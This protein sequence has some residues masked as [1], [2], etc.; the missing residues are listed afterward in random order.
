M[1][2]ILTIITFFHLFSSVGWA[3]ARV[4]EIE[5]FEIRSYDPQKGGLTDLVFEARIGNLTEI[6]NKVQ[7]FG[8]LV[9]VYF[10]IYWI[11]PAQYKVEVL[12]LPKGFA[13][14]RSDLGDLIKGK[15]EFIIPERFSEKFKGYTFKVEPLSSGKLIKA[16]D[17]SY[18]MAVP[19][20]D[21]IFDSAGRLKTLETKRTYTAMKSDF[22]HSPKSWSNG[23][24]VLDKIITT[25]TSGLT[26]KETSSIVDYTSIAGIGLPSKV[27]IKNIET[28]TIPA[29]GKEK[30]KIIKNESGTVVK[31]SNYEVNTGKAQRFIMEGLRR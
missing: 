27:E 26:K 7:T 17:A 14:V 24:L 31:F 29:K 6:L 3:Q 28:T 30:E 19:E 23:K 22:F 5:Q 12:G 2:L 16:I 20:I 25:S 4:E 9:E 11:S 8:K 13:E 18:T 15:L 21:L 1:K 10:K